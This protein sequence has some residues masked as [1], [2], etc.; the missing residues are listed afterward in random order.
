MTDNGPIEKSLFNLLEYIEREKYLGYD[1]YDVLQSK[2]FKQPLFKN[3]KWIRFGVQ[4]FGKR[5]PISIRPLLG[6][7][8]SLNPV[9]LGLCIQGYSELYKIFPERQQTYAAIIDGLI[10]RLVKLIPEGYHGSCWGYNFDWEARYLKVPAY[11]PTIVATGLISNALFLWY[12]TSGSKWAFELCNGASEFILNDINRTY[13]GDGNFCFSYS[14]FDKLKVF[15]ASMKGVRTLSQ[16]YSVT[17][18]AVL[19][20]TAEKAASYVMSG[21]RED[22]AWVYSTQDSGGWVDNYHT[23]YI[24]DCL[25]EFIRCTGDQKFIPQ[26]ERGFIFYRRNFFTDAGIPKFY[27]RKIYP[28]DSTSAAQSIL[29]LIRFGELELAKK[30]AGWMIANMQSVNGNFYF[31]KFSGYTIRT[32]F[33]RWS[34]AWM[35]AALG[36]LLSG[37]KQLKEI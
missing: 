7:N 17:K 24:L 12:K 1:P 36:S 35:F 18:D 25:D 2:L 8:K 34:N 19:K 27:D 22:G 6:V 4:Q 9:T 5:F 16:I 13:N 31:R 33:M 28:V 11:Q 14:P 15:N 21:Q 32:S 26:M 37:V 30:V 29:T 23:G 20:S 10:D 3:N